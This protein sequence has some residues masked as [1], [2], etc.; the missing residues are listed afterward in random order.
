MSALAHVVCKLKKTRAIENEQTNE[1]RYRAHASAKSKEMQRHPQA[2][3]QLHHICFC[4]N[5]TADIDHIKR[6]KNKC[7]IQETLFIFVNSLQK[8]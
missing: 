1:R 5:R 3:A 6:T 4:P 2:I 8:M 7:Y